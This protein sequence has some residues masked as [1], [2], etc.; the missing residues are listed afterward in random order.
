MA[1]FATA[2][3]ALAVTGIYAMIAYSVSQRAREI[4]IGIA[5]GDG[6]SSVVDWMM[7]QGIRFVSI[8]LVVGIAM[9]VAR[10]RLLSNM[11]FGV[12][13][14][15]LETYGQEAGV[16]AAVSAIAC[17]GPAAGLEHL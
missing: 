11:L 16:V 3:L 5:L 13:A 15:D 4:G 9:A 6:R 14:T 12:S 10:M 2:A 8:G 17:A 7:G 1:A